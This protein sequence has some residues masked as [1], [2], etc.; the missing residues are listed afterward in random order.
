NEGLVEMEVLP[1]ISTL[2]AETVPISANVFAP[3]IAKRAAQTR[4]VVADGK[5][6]VIGGLMEDN[7]TEQVR[8][9]PL[10]GD[11]PILGVLFRRTI[12]NKTKTE[13]LIFLTPYVIRNIRALDDVTADERGRTRIMN[14]A[15]DDARQRQYF[16]D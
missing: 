13:L 5:T 15:V 4:V 12:I 11:L 1:E 10:L 2:T 3:V 7:D 16:D 14:Q 8:K 9:V 6:V